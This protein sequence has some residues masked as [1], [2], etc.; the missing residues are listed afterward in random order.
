MEHRRRRRRGWRRRR[1]WRWRGGGGDGGVGGEEEE[2]GRRRRRRRSDKLVK[3][4]ELYIGQL[5]LAS[6]LFQESH[7]FLVINCFMAEPSLSTS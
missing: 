3:K 5:R 2:V 1:W 7:T 6:E 4:V